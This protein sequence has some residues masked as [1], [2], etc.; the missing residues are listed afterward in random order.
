MSWKVASKSSSPMSMITHVLTR[1]WFY[2]PLVS[3]IKW[4]TNHTSFHCCSFQKFLSVCGSVVVHL[5][6]YLVVELDMCLGSSIHTHS[7]VVVV[8]YLQGKNM[9][10]NLYFVQPWVASDTIPNLCNLV[11][12]TVRK[13]HPNTFF[14]GSGNIFGTLE[15]GSQYVL[16]VSPINQGYNGIKYTF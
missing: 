8:M 12:H 9:N 4:Y 11:R 5:K 15:S 10:L 13:Q 6:S 16:V 1:N 2:Q 7:Q 3:H 14:G